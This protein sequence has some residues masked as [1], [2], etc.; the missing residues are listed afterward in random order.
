VD[1]ASSDYM[2]FGYSLQPIVDGAFLAHAVLRAPVQLWERL[3][4]PVQ[5]HLVAALRATRS[6]K[7]HF[8]NWLLFA[9]M[10]EVGLR[11]MG[12]ADW[13][14]MR[15]D[16]ALRQ[17]EAWYV[18][19]G[20]YKDGPELHADYYNSLVIQPMLV[21]II[22]EVGDEEADWAALRP[23]ILKRA[24]RYGGIL[25]RSISPEGTFP[26]LGRSLAY[27]CGAMQHLAQM[28][29]QETLPEGVTPAQVRCAL[30]A[31]VRR[32]L[33]PAGTFDAGGWLTV[34]FA[35][36]QPEVGEMYISTGACGWAP[37]GGWRGRASSDVVLLGVWPRCRPAAP[38]CVVPLLRPSPRRLLLPCLGRVPAARPPRGPPLLG[39]PTGRLDEQA[40]VGRRGSAD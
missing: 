5:A 36:H 38:L 37:G 20:L 6:R 17:H 28:A 40:D 23:G 22:R 13:D 10:I 14:R 4:P 3:P 21:D 16:Y 34:G 25:E 9:A 29:L 11:R 19:D 35:G 39:K 32:S 8:N 27:R 12:A 18:G 2:N 31:V 24:V 33:G 15:I 30:A 7:P 1:P 26:P